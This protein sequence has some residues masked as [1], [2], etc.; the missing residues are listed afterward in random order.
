MTALA[1]IE[2]LLTRM[3]TTPDED[4]AAAVLDDASAAVRSYCG[5]DF[6]EATTTD[7]LRFRRGRLR[8]PQR[9]VLSVDTIVD[10]AGAAVAATWDGLDQLAVITPTLGDFETNITATTT[11]TGVVDVTYSH[12]YDP[13]PD[14]IVAVVCNI[15]ARSLG[16]PPEAAPLSGESITNYS[17]TIGPVGAAGT[18]GLFADERALLDRYR[19]AAG[20]S[21]AAP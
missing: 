21:W 7:R 12:G 19:T 8:L 1:T 5:Q 11:W 6:D 15:A 17:Y 2:Q 10:V 18:V 13:I 16:V 4:R 20:V 3:T 9:P 14:D